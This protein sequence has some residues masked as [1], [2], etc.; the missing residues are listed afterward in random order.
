MP[1]DF[2][3]K[4][5]RVSQ[6]IASGGITGQPKLG[7][8]IYSASAASSLVGGMNSHLTTRIGKVGPDTFF[9]VDGTPNYR[10]TGS[11]DAGNPGSTVGV[12]VFGGDVVISGTLYSERQIVEIEQTR[13]GSFTLDGELGVTGS[14]KFLSTVFID[15]NESANYKALEIDS[16]STEAPA[17]YVHGKYALTA[18]QDITDGFAAHFYRNIA[19]AG[20]HPLVYMHDDNTNNTQTTLKIQQDGTGDI[21]NLFDGATEVMTVIDGGKVGIGQSTPTAKLQI[22][23]SDSDNMKGLYLNFDETGNH[24]ALYIDSEGAY[25]AIGIKAKQGMRIEQDVSSGYGLQVDRDI[26]EGGSNPLVLFHDDNTNNTQTTLTVRQDGTGD[27][28]NLKDGTTEVMTVTDGGKVGIGTDSPG[29]KLALTVADT[30][31][32]GGLLIDFNETGAYKALEIDSESTSGAALESK[33]KYAGYFLQDITSGYAGYFTR[34][35]AEAGSN[36]LVTIHDDHTNTTQP[37]LSVRTDGSADIFNFTYA[38]SERMALVGND[39]ATG[40]GNLRLTGSFYVKS[41]NSIPLGVDYTWDKVTIK[42]HSAGNASRTAFEVSG[43]LGRIIQATAGGAIF[44]TDGGD[45]DF[46]IASDD[47]PYAFFVDG[48]NDSVFIGRSSDPSGKIGDLNVF[49]SSNTAL[50]VDKMN[51]TTGSIFFTNQDRVDAELTLDTNENFIIQSNLTDADITIKVNDGGTGKNI[52]L[53]DSSRMSVSFGE[54]FNN[55]S[56]NAII[57]GGLNNIINANAAAATIGGGSYNIV[58]AASG[59]IAGGASNKVAGNGDEGTIGGGSG[60]LITKRNATIAGG[61]SGSISGEMGTIGGG[62]SNTVSGQYGT[63]PGGHGN[64]VSSYAG[65]VLGG[66]GSNV[67]GQGSIAIGTGLQ[68]PV[69]NIIAI[70]GGILAGAKHTYQTVLSSTLKLPDIGA[71]SNTDFLVIDAN[72]VV[73]RNNSINPD[74]GIPSASYAENQGSGNWISPVANNNKSVAIGHHAQALGHYSFAAGGRSN[75]IVGGG[76]YSTILGGYDN[77]AGSNL[78]TILG[79]SGSYA[80]MPGSFIIGCGITSSL[81]NSVILGGGRFHENYNIIISGSYTKF[82]N[83]GGHGTHL[84]LAYDPWSDDG[85][86]GPGNADAKISFSRSGTAKWAMGFDDSNSDKFKIVSG[87]DLGLASI[88]EISQSEI[89]FN[90]NNDNLDFVIEGKSSSKELFVLD[91]GNEMVTITGPAG[92][93]TTVFK[94]HGNNDA[95]NGTANLFDV[96][97]TEVIVNEGSQDVNFRVESQNVSSMFHVDASSN[98]IG[99]GTGT[100][101]QVLHIVTGTTAGPVIQIENINNDAAGGQI[102]FVK[103]SGNQADNDELGKINFYGKDSG[104]NATNFAYI[105]GRSIDVSNNDEGGELNFYVMAGG[106][107]GTADEALLFSIGGEVAGL[108]GT[109]AEVVVNDVG[110]NC[111]FRVEGENATKMLWVDANNDIVHIQGV[112]GD[113]TELFRI[114]GNND[115]DDDIESILEVSPTEVCINEDSNDVDFRVESATG[116]HAIYVN[117][118][119][120]EVVIN[121]DSIDM[122]FRVESNGNANMLFVDGGEDRIGINTAAP[123]TDLHIVSGLSGNPQVKIQNTHADANGAKI[124]FNKSTTS[125]GDNDELGSIVFTGMDSANN[126]TT[127]AKIQGLNYDVTNGSEQGTIHLMVAEYDGT[128]TEGLTLRGSNTDGEIHV[129]I[130]DSTPSY[131]LDVNGVT[132]FRHDVRI[133]YSGNSQGGNILDSSSNTMLSFDQSGN[134]DVLATITS[135]V[136]LDDGD[137]TIQSDANYPVLTLESNNNTNYYGWLAFK[138]SDGTN[139]SKSGTDSGETLGAISWYGYNTDGSAYDEAVKITAFVDGQP[140]TSTDSSD[141]PG[142]LIIWTAADGGTSPTARTWWHSNGHLSHSGSIS[143]TG[144]VGIGTPPDST[145]T[146]HVEDSIATNHVAMFDNTNTASTSDGICIRIGPTTAS[147]QGYDNVF[148]R[149]EDGDGTDVG[150]LRADTSGGAALWSAFTG[151]HPS[152]MV[153]EDVMIGLIVGS[154]GELWADRTTHV[155][156]AIPKVRLTSSD[157][158]KIVFGVIAAIDSHPGYTKCWGI[159]EDETQVYINGLGE[160]K[161]WVTDKNGN[162]ENGDY[163]TTS[164]ISGYG[165]KQADDIL[166]NY[167]VAKCVETVD[168]S[169]VTDTIDHDGT[170]FK[171]Y[172]IGCTYHCS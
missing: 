26:A 50:V 74:T 53:F 139:A 27:I 162:I 55:S 172:L 134:I 105:Q 160:G 155:S 34:N 106:T 112:A 37:A 129:G 57:G 157:N 158:S 20:S 73:T 82:V 86:G 46:R 169:S 110:M 137:L 133:G 87:S 76:T 150:K 75:E 44:N 123:D 96:K 118:G 130:M 3:A 143:T 114:S 141:M 165:M 31:N 13:S 47:N 71:S 42:G 52:G 6:L 40:Q 107:A 145:Y 103:T 149:M 56:D 4:H 115:D 23:V 128:L 170:A 5:I 54:G 24:N 2:N 147:N 152:V 85:E 156:T 35:I 171:K 22:D 100:P 67:S 51:G 69:A 78:V 43:S 135:D 101:T 121:E 80:Q 163:I 99:I 28:L 151:A 111:D 21:L 117:A 58:S 84:E 88:M 161:V 146:L 108:G 127:Y 131:P 116:T 45:Q 102:S 132:A 25:P 109:V 19:E 39:P 59:T 79:G 49:N 60:H 90:N 48:G 159:D 124:E 144:H 70:G 125:E 167:T 8:A 120:P 140:S 142:G 136:T 95:G 89:R 32:I 77:T 61:L 15:Q 7:L 166:R 68:V 91:A 119:A 113:N 30:E 97:P 148:V 41:S 16:E 72:G 62:S 14:A 29:V 9:Y 63:I 104:G 66:T 168:W 92:D 94:V 36:P 93:D 1:R 10:Q 64:T 12:T 83:E 33:G 154:T 17:F 153:S 11:L 138:R 98:M 164:V 38:G 122:N 81:S 18:T 126:V 65:A